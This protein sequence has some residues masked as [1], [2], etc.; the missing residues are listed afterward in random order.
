MY[1]YGRIG[2]S[3]LVK[4]LRRDREMYERRQ[5]TSIM[6]DFKLLNKLRFRKQFN[7]DSKLSQLPILS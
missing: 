5:G 6:A 4:R 2:I 7:F 1:G 3:N